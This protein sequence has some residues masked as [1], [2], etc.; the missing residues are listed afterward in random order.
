VARVVI[1]DTHIACHLASVL[2]KRGKLDEAEELHRQEVALC[3]TNMEKMTSM[4]GLARVLASG[5][6]Y[7]EA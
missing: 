7:D 3:Q 4:S 6:R 2:S 5:G 1:V